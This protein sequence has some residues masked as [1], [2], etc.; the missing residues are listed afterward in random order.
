MLLGSTFHNA[1]EVC[2]YYKDNIDVFIRETE[3]PQ[4]WEE[5]LQYQLTCRLNEV[6][7][8]T[9]EEIEKLA[10]GMCNRDTFNGNSLGNIVA[11]MYKWAGGMGLE[12]IN[13]EIKL[14]YGQFV[15]TLDIVAKN[16][17]G[18]LVIIDIKTSGMWSKLL[19]G[20]STTK[21]KYS[22][23]QL[24]HHPQLKHYHWL[25]WKTEFAKLE[26]VKHYG[27]G[28]PANLIPY[29][30]GKNKGKVRDVP[31]QMANINHKAVRRYE[32]DMFEWLRQIEEGNFIRTYPSIYGKL[33]CETCPF[34]NECLSDQDTTFVP[35]Y[36]K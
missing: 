14:K 11:E 15:G 3:T 10:I 5:Q 22:P 1:F 35:E 30:T 6:Y 13:N 25:I 9:P 31:Y 21:Q 7:D 2:S 36:L 12:I 4:W 17:I 8:V 29:S 28:L 24:R 27:I 18:D 33:M 32:E 19:N 26:E 20:K 23:D 16:L 34:V